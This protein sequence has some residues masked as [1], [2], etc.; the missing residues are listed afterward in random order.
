MGVTLKQK[1]QGRKREIKGTFIQRWFLWKGTEVPPYLLG[2]K[3]K[4]NFESNM[5][6][7]QESMK[8]L[9]AIILIKKK[10]KILQKRSNVY[11]LGKNLISVKHQHSF[12]ALL[13]FANIM[14]A[15]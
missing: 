2:E 7:D 13:N 12:L 9:R 4:Y 5:D 11:S 8:V 6:L 14:E 10:R 15:K 3:P 1:K